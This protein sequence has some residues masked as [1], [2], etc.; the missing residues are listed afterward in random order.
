MRLKLDFTLTSQEER[1]HFLEKYLQKEE[2][3]ENPPTEVELE[4]MADYLLW[5]KT[6]KGKNA[7]QEGIHIKTK[8]HTWD[9]RAFESLDNLLESP[10]FN[11][12][13]VAA[14]GSTQFRAKRTT[15]SR[16]EALEKCLPSMR[17]DFTKLFRLIDETDYLVC[18]YDEMRGRRSKPIRSSLADKFTPEE[19]QKMRERAETWTEYRYLKMRHHLVELRREQYLLRDAHQKTMFVIDEQQ[20]QEDP[21]V[22]FDAGIEVLPLGAKH[23][24]N[25]VASLIFQPWRDLIPANFGKETLQAISDLYWQKKKCAPTAQELW[26]DFRDA[27]HVY[28]LLTFLGDLVGLEDEQSHSTSNLGALLDTLNFY[29]AQADLTDAQRFVLDKKLAK[30]RNADI[31]WEVN[32]TFDKTYTVNYISTIFKQKIIPKICAAAAYHEK[33]VGDLFFEEQFKTC[34]DCGRVL[35]RSSDN[36]TRKARAIDGFTNRCKC[37]E[38]KI[39]LEKQKKKLEENKN[40]DT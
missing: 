9:K 16:E 23:K 24:N 3:Q 28:W 10:T 31:A 2:F 5:G 6:P 40:D 25:E 20:Y 12:S 38:K 27:N 1:N 39:R 8:H 32:H 35:L 33:I 36:F 21:S 13:A 17:E 11:E 19:Q 30:W 29:V 14:L 15:F 26:F 7:K 18:L 37:C 34:A 22:D 4:T